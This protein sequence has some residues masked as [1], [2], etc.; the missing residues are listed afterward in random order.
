VA[1]VAVKHFGVVAFTQ[2]H[3]FSS[4]YTCCNFNFDFAG[5]L[6]E[7]EISVKGRLASGRA[8]ALN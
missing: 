8:N 4:V 1:V 2:S 6:L 7:I 5:I 3:I